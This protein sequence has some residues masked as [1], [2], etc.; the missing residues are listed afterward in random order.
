M[1]TL[2]DEAFDGKAE[3]PAADRRRGPQRHATRSPRGIHIGISILA[4]LLP[5]ARI[6]QAELVRGFEAGLK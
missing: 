1:Q 3:H 2:F 5:R 4:P 6:M